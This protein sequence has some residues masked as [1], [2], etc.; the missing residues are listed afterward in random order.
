MLFFVVMLSA[1]IYLCDLFTHILQDCFPCVWGSKWNAPV[2]LE[3]SVCIIHEMRYV[4]CKSMGLL[5]DPY[6]CGLRMRWECRERFPTTDLKESAR[7]S[8]P[9]MHHG[10]CVMH[11][12]W[13][14]S[15]SLTSGGGK[16]VPGSSRRMRNPQFYV[17]G[18]RPMSYLAIWWHW[19]I[20]AKAHK[21]YSDILR[22]RVR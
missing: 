1:S 15:G 18:K 20:W 3:T 13:C 7:V 9:G 6:N 2:L 21:L 16:N 10:T 5:P 17:S 4:M 12:P 22:K 11:V 14:M 8:D 19:I